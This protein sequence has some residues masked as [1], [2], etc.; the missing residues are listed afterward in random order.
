M[1][2]PSQYYSGIVG[3]DLEG[4]LPNPTV[5]AL[6]GVD[7]IGP[8]VSP[9]M[10]GYFLTFTDGYMQLEPAPSGSFLAG[11]DLTGT[12]I[13]QVVN[14]IQGVIITGVPNPGDVMTATDATDASWQPP[15]APTGSAGG[16]LSGSYP[17]PQVVQL[18]GSIVLSG[19]PSVGQVLEA[20]SSTA[21]HWA[22]AAGDIV[23]PLSSSLV[24]KISGPSLNGNPL[25]IGNIHS[26]GP[27]YSALYMLRNGI[28][29]ADYSGFLTFIDG[30][31]GAVASTVLGDSSNAFNN[32]INNETWGPNTGFN[33]PSTAGGPAYKGANIGT[34]NFTSGSTTLQSAFMISNV[35]G[36]MFIN[37]GTSPQSTIVCNSQDTAAGNTS[38]SLCSSFGNLTGPYS[39][40]GQGMECVGLT[41][42]LS[43]LTVGSSAL[44]IICGDMNNPRVI[45][46]N[47]GLAYNANPVVVAS[48]GTTTLPAP[49][50]VNNPQS[51]VVQ[52][53]S[54]VNLTGAATLDFGGAI[55]F[56]LLDC[57]QLT[58]VTVGVNTFSVANGGGGT[59]DCSTMLLSK[60]LLTVYC[61]TSTTL[62]VG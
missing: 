50:G 8:F 42:N 4:S 27:T 12:D 56:F 13:N 32:P 22:G 38:I 39:G 40:L 14:S 60:N 2:G 49:T 21:A 3:G 45:I 24:E 26:T 51:Y 1:T 31:S 37:Q 47:S 29:N 34:T 48:S 28:S 61:A 57:S 41:T 33:G 17:S 20:T 10:D 62:A 52:Q 11:G 44:S 25:T 36:R 35:D 54:S 16:D 18:Q 58:G 43:A 19:T 9:E 55:G 46:N 53:I 30:S 15:A 59:F 5:K 6:N 7:V 23:G